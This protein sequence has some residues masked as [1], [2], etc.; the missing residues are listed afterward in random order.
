[1]QKN[2]SSHSTPS[3]PPV[4]RSLAVPHEPAGGTMTAVSRALLVVS[5]G[6]WSAGGVLGFVD[7]TDAMSSYF[8]MHPRC[9]VVSLVR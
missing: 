9:W 3:T 2:Q 8:R 1:M 7:L 6:V 4:I 5:L